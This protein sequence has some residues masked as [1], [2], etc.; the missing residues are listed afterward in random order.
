MTTN[1]FSL[2]MAFLHLAQSDSSVVGF[3]TLSFLEEIED[4]DLNEYSDFTD[5]ESIS[6]SESLIAI[7]LE[8][9]PLTIKALKRVAKD[10]MSSLCLIRE[11]R[12]TRLNCTAF[13]GDLSI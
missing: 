2:A 8:A 9:T 10:F 11:L 5:Y 1:C 7:L 4:R 13:L 12:L 6:D 3:D